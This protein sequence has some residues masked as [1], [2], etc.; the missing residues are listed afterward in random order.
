MPLALLI[1]HCHVVRL[2]SRKQLASSNVARGRR[3]RGGA[4]AARPLGPRTSLGRGKAPPRAVTEAR[5]RQASAAERRSAEYR[6]RRTYTPAFTLLPSAVGDG[7]REARTCPAE[8]AMGVIGVQ[9][10]QEWQE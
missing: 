3:E 2:A 1:Q 4:P 10:W 7:C 6:R 8:V 5:P 9:E